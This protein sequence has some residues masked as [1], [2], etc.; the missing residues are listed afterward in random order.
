[1]DNDTEDDNQTQNT[2]LTGAIYLLGLYLVGLL[3][4]Y[5]YTLQIGRLRYINLFLGP[6]IALFYLEQYRSTTSGKQDSVD[7]VSFLTR[8]GM[9]YSPGNKAT[10]ASVTEKA[11]V[12]HLAFAGLA[13]L[14]TV[15]V[16][17][18][19]ER[20]RFD[21]P[22]TGTT[23]VDQLVGLVL[24]II[25]IHATR[26]AYG[27][28]ISLVTILTIVYG[29]AGPVFPGIFRHTGMTIP[30]LAVTGAIGLRGVYGFIMDIGATWVAIFIVFAGMAKSFGLIDYVLA[31]G[32][33]LSNFFRSGIVHAAVISSL[34]IG[35]LTGSAAANIA[36][37]GSFTIPLMRQQGIDGKY[38]AAI[39]SVVSAGAQVMPPVMGVAAFLM[40]DIL[41]ISYVNVISAGLLP[42]ILFYAAI[43]IGIHLLVL[44]MGWTVESEKGIDPSVFTT[45]IY[46]VVPLG[47]LIYTLVVLRLTPL[48]AGF[49][50]ILSLIAVQILR[51][52]LTDP[53]T[54]TVK[55]T[56]KEL[57]EGGK[58]GAL[59]MAPLL[60]VLGAMG[61]IVEIITETGLSQKLSLQIISLAGGVFLVLLLLAMV[62]SILFGLGMPTPAA[63][64]LVVFLVAPALTD[65]GV[66]DLTAHYFVF[67]FAMLSAITPPVAI[68]VAIGSKIANVGFVPTAIQ[69]LRIGG[70]CFVLPYVFITNESLI[71]WAFPETIITFG[72][73]LVGFAMLAIVFINYDG[74]QKPGGSVRGVYAILVFGAFFASRPIQ[75]AACV[76][77]IIIFVSTRRFTVSTALTN[78]R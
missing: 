30:E 38:A 12:A 31:I 13:L 10:L 67:Y 16:E 61:I 32:E 56:G 27:W 72:A 1:M 50:T 43:A 17:F 6:G 52:L 77:G 5:A 78:I 35:S 58:E 20:L 9:N 28:A 75:I 19:F 42:A 45:G 25:V 8:I 71:V 23:G 53:S 41:G 40:A 62:T 2:V 69:A 55:K 34:F 36:T 29:L 74:R 39:E 18:H 15:Y 64:I 33:E 4:Y 46:F 11:Y 59:E 3:L 68:C 54:K 37:T 63:Y 47:V 70:P 51:N 24:I 22:I 49:Y 73:V 48:S 66:S 57:V 65:A 14:T 44:R 76:V 26:V 21:A 60:G 7:D